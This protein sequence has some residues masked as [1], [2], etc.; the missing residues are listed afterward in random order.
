MKKMF[1]AAFVLAS[2]VGTSASASESNFWGMAEN[3]GHCMAFWSGYVFNAERGQCEA[4]SASGCTNPF[5]FETLED[6][7]SFSRW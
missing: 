6:C 2:A 4:R 3:S 5:L 7:E 1:L